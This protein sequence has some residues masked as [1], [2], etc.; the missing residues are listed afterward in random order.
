M[1]FWCDS[2][3]ILVMILMWFGWWF[4]C[5][6]DEKK[7]NVTYTKNIK[8]TNGSYKTDL[9]QRERCWN[10]TKYV[11]GHRNGFFLQFPFWTMVVILGG[12]LKICNDWFCGT[13]ESS[14]STFVFRGVGKWILGCA[15]GNH[16][17]H[18]VTFIEQVANLRFSIKLNFKIRVKLTAD[19]S[20]LKR[21]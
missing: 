3:V 15:T 16:L 6:P 14:A 9:P 4:W 5:D 10:S 20:R 13:F 7:S 18:F 11:I 8:I 12:W 21:K 17:C 1:W 19:Q 2:D